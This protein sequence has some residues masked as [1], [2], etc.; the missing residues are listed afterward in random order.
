M[1]DRKDAFIAQR[2]A[3]LAR[4][5]ID[6]R[7]FIT[8]LV[9][10]GVAVPAALSMADRARAA[11]PQRGGTFRLGMAHGSTTDSLDPATYE[12]GM[13]TNTGFTYGNNLIEVAPDGSLRPELAESY[14]ALDG[15]KSWAFRIRK[16]VEFHNAKT[17]T[18]DD[19]I[20]SIN[21][22]RGEA[23]KSAAKGLLTSIT[24][25]RKDGEDVVV[26]DLDAPNADFPFVITDY[27]LLILPSEDGEIDPT[28][29]IGTGGYVIR[30]FEP[31]VRMQATRNPNY[32]KEDAAFFDE[33][34]L[35]SIIDVT[36]RQNALMSG[37]VSAADRLDPKTVAL[38]QR[39]PNVNIIEQ[40]G[41]LHYT[42]P[43][44]LDTA[45]FGDYD[46]RMALKYAV[47]KQEMVDKILLGH[48]TIGNDHPISPIVPF[49][50]EGLEQREFDADK[51]KFHYE[52]SGHSGPI[53]LSAS[54]AAFAGALDAAQLLQASAAECG[55]EVEIVREPSDGYWSNVWNKKGWCACYW[56]GRPTC[57]WMF[58]SGY[59]EDQEWNDTAW[60]GTEAADRFNALVVEARAEL[61]EARRAEMYFECQRLIHDDGGSI[62]PMFANY[63]MGAGRGVQTPEVIAGNWENDGYKSVERWWFA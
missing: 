14:E 5:R 52:K 38:L 44:R 40:V 24:D 61:D 4:G 53:Q 49:H 56:G 50:A 55:I 31:G 57:D 39:A 28:A 21:Y 13:M 46:L 3:Q 34:E 18:A 48:G 9:A 22:H 35:V 8:S 27:H 43:M 1:T 42:F 23:S 54:T 36:A 37:E 41:Y 60:R 63:I 6:R 45:P 29:G 7:S 19:V 47:K 11:T 58:S 12:N 62:V 20:A 26:F 51:A 30:N 15:G 25:I 16:G 10:A 59:V 2:K 33:V 32:F 17:M